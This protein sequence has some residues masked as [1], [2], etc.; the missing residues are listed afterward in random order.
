MKIRYWIIIKP[1]RKYNFN[2]VCSNFF[3]H[4]AIWDKTCECWKILFSWVINLFKYIAEVIKDLEGEAEFIGGGEESYGYL[5]GDKVRDK[6]AVAS[7]A[8]IAE[9]TAWAKG[10]GLSIF[11]LLKSIYKEHGLFVESLKSITKKG[12]SGAEEISQM[13]SS[14]SLLKV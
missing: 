6:D 10:E 9:M 5:I 11:D 2:E 3:L 13:I 7:C 8:M 14:C 1:N 4:L 12:M